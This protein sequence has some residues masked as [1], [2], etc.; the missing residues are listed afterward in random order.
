MTNPLDKDAVKK[1][2][3][4]FCHTKDMGLAISA[5]LDAMIE[6]KKAWTETKQRQHV[7]DFIPFIEPFRVLILKL[8]DE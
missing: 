2:K 1:A 3:L 4:R 7:P 8:G 5:Y 6:S